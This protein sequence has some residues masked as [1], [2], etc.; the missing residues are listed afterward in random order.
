LDGRHVLIVAGSRFDATVAAGR[1]PG[2]ARRLAEFLASPRWMVAF[3]VLAAAGAL[4]VAY[5][6]TAA[7]R[8]M[9]IPLG[10]LAL[11]LIAAISVRP[12]LR[13]DAPLLLLH[14][15]LLALLLLFTFAR[16]TYF[17]A[18]T[19]LTSGVPFE[20][21]FVRLERGPFHHDRIA[22]LRFVNAGFTENFPQRGR[23]KAT[24]NR[25]RWWDGDGNA[26]EAVIG[27]DHPLILGGYRVYTSRFRGFSPVFHWVGNDGAEDLGTVQLNDTRM[28]DFAH[29]TSWNTPAGDEVWAMLDLHADEASTPGTQRRNLAVDVLPHVLVLRVGETRHELRPG[30]S[31][32]LPSGQLHYLRLDSWIGYRVIYDPTKPWLVSTVAVIVASLVWFYVRRFKRRL[33]R[34]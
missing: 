26:H 15:A 18:S 28:G 17:D 24:Y 32:A 11:S 27:D 2:V 22:E 9:P 6:V 14:L 30:E 3:F 31:L 5:E 8:V 34:E 25:V 7:T 23:Y 13:A 20:G 1:Q 12:A 16:L 29:S 10:L 33:I 21:E 4:A 19:V